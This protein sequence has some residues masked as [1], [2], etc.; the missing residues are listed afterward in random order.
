MGIFKFFTAGVLPKKATFKTGFS[1]KS[2]S[3]LFKKKKEKNLNI[4]KYDYKKWAKKE[5][6]DKKNEAKIIKM[7][8][9][10][11][12]FYLLFLLLSVCLII[13]FFSAFKMYLLLTLFSTLCVLKIVANLYKKRLQT[14][15]Q[16][17]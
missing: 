15:K 17:R 3:K 5:C 16:E 9:I 7:L 8:Y 1:F 10:E 13:V 12:A 2:F 14:V 4:D 11:I 6:I